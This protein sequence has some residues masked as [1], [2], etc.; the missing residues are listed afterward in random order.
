MDAS[1]SMHDSACTKE[2]GMCAWA[3]DEVNSTCSNRAQRSKDVK[4]VLSSEPSR[5][6]YAVMLIH[7]PDYQLSYA[8]SGDIQW[9]W[10]KFQNNI[11]FSIASTLM[12]SFMPR[13][14]NVP[15][16]N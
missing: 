4:V 13:L 7:H 12:V 11:R 5:G 6:D 10:V 16:C 9:N 2:V 8:S 1:G 14:F 3:R 15:S